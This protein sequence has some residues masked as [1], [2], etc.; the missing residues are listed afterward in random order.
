MTLDDRSNWVLEKLRSDSGEEVLKF[1]IW[2]FWDTPPEHIPSD[3]QALEW[4]ILQ[5][6]PDALEAAIKQAIAECDDFVRPPRRTS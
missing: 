6:R 5:Q 2:L 4:K 3:E 1:I